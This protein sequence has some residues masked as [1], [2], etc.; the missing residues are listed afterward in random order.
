MD[1]G[2]KTPQ[3]PHLSR[4]IQHV[5]FIAWIRQCVVDSWLELLCQHGTVHGC[6]M[7]MHDHK[8]LLRLSV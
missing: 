5:A 2:D 6:G 4:G 3:C 8:N 1:A 7:L